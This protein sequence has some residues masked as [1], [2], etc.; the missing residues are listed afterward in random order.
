MAD[1]SIYVKHEGILTVWRVQR[2]FEGGAEATPGSTSGIGWCSRYP[3]PFFLA[4]A[5]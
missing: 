5:L 3:L 1:G 4:L 2:I